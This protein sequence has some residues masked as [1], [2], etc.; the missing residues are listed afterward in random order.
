MSRKLV[1]SKDMR[2]NMKRNLTGHVVTRWYR[3]PELILLEKD[4]GPAID[5]WA[6]G[7]IFGELLS[8]IKE[9]AKTF[10]DRKPL[11]PGGSCF[12]LSPDSN[13]ANLPKTNGFPMATND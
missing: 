10:M 1:K 7:C 8:M 11:F 6:I 13:Q 5:V 3:A 2:K 12:P 4:Y 9:N